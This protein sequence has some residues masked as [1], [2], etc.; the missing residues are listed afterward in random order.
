MKFVE[1]KEYSPTL[2]REMPY[3]IYGHQGKPILVFPS[4]GGSHHEYGDFGMIEACRTFIDEGKVQFITPGSM[5]QES[6]LA[7]GRSGGEMAAVHN[8]YDRYV[9]AE[10]LPAIRRDTGWQGSLLSTG[11]SMGAYH[12]LN[13]FL[14]HPDV[15]DSTVA[16]SGVYDIRGFTSDV[17]D[18]A[19][20]GNSPA[21]YLWN[22]HDPWFL[23]RYR[24]AKIIIC[25][26]QGAWEE[27]GI[28]DTKKMEAVFA[29]KEIPAWIDYWGQ[30]VNHDWF[31]W[32]KQMPYFLDHLDRQGAFL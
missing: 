28:A 17:D 4:S 19:V 22:L 2:K 18:P 26:G 31:W 25:V 20:Y 24:R 9:I 27:I 30:D 16:L 8:R 7:K 6:W 12:A 29:A 21:D 32:R 11:C 3:N 23:D 15:F 1:K 5:D 14:R 13:F 10:L